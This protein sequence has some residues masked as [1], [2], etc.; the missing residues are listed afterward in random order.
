MSLAAVSQVLA[1]VSDVLLASL[2]S[3]TDVFPADTRN[4]IKVPVGADPG[5][6]LLR[7]THARLISFVAVSSSQLLTRL[8]PHLPQIYSTPTV[9][10]V[11][12][13]NDI[14]DVLLLRSALPFF[15][16]STTAQQAYDNAI[17]AST[18]ARQERKAVVHA[19]YLGDS[20]DSASLASVDAVRSLVTGTLSLVYHN[21]NTVAHSF[22]QLNILP[23]LPSRPRIPSPSSSAA[24]KQQRKQLL[25]SPGDPRHLS[26]SR[27]MPTPPPCYSSLG[28]PLFHPSALEE[29]ASPLCPC[30]THFLHPSSSLASLHPY[31]V[32]WL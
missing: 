17:L 9:L 32:S 21:M 13:F 23:H 1:A 6:A 25:R 4:L 19:F 27:A 26:P 18:L 31:N 12:V 7:H 22:P 28:V 24:T 30:S 16:L 5:P 11:A 3:Y 8:V 20:Q 14:S 15:L 10:H 29:S 2:P